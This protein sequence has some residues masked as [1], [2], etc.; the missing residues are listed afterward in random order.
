MSVINLQ[1]NVTSLFAALLVVLVFPSFFFQKLG[2]KYC[3]S[4]TYLNG[5][6]IGLAAV[7]Q[8]PVILTINPL[9]ALVGILFVSK[10]D[11]SL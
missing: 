10:S 3:S 7:T 5:A 8:E 2:K 4:M 11:K 1:S 6:V 9:L